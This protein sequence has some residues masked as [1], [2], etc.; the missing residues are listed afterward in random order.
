MDMNLEIWSVGLIILTGVIVGVINTFAGAGA[1][2]TIALFS[3]LGMPL[4]IANATNRISVLFQ[5]VTM[6]VGFHRQGLLD[7]RLGLR[8]SVP[9]IIG[10]IIGSQV[11]SSINSTLFAVLLCIVLSLMLI[12]LI[13]DPT[14]AINGKLIRVAPKHYHYLLLLGIGFYGG[15]FH[16]GIG[17]LF[18]MLFIMG[19]GYD[20]LSA[21]ALKGFV[22]LLYTI[23]AIAV[24]AYNNQINWSYGLI[25]S[26][27]NIIGAYFAT[28]YS[29]FIPIKV[30]RY[31]L[32]VFIF[33]TTTYIILYKL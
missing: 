13:Y 17:Y 28:K 23:F 24:F 27:G 6:S 7:W 19:L 21:N 22:V 29:K 10:S 26:I 18:L 8:L 2:I 4:P 5:T 1:S 15:A 20:L 14:K 25:H 32:M 16:I 33:L 12:M 31:F 30:L 3:M 9:T 11:A